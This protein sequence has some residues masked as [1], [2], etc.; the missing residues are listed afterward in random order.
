MASLLRSSMEIVRPLGRCTETLLGILIHGTDR[1][2]T[3][4]FRVKFT[5]KRSQNECL[6][7]AGGVGVGS[8]RWRAVL[9]ER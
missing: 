7:E 6:K 9:A 1:M 3:Q 5:R 2:A 8:S 4:L